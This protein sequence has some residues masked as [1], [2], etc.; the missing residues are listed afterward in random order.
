MLKKILFTLLILTGTNRAHAL[1]TLNITLSLPADFS[2]QVCNIPVWNRT[3]AIWGHVKD[4][5][6]EKAVGHQSKNGVDTLLVETTPPLENILDISLKRLFQTCGMEWVKEEDS[7]AI[8][9]SVN[10]LEFF[11]GSDKKLLTG[12]GT[13]V[14]RLAINIEKSNQ[15]LQTIEVGFQIENKGIRQ[16]KL[17]Q[18]EKTLNEL[19]ADTLKQIPRLSQMK[20]F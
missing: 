12:K 10:I 18:L 4:L 17:K 5:R 15:T 1:E 2:T 13:A 9:I 19:L 7:N 20:D 16:A 8:K 3:K 6:E 14:S 11:A